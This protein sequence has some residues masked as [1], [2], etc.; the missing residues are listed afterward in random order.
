MIGALSFII[1]SLIFFTDSRGAFELLGDDL[2][3]LGI[4]GA[5]CAGSR[6]AGIIGRNPALLGYVSIPGLELFQRRLYNMKELRQSQVLLQGRILN[7]GFQ[8]GFHDFGNK[9]YRETAIA[10]SA[11]RIIAGKVSVGVRFTAFNL[12]IKDNGSSWAGGMRGGIVWRPLP[13]FALGLTGDNLNRPV[14]GACRERLPVRFQGGVS[15]FPGEWLS[16]YADIFKEERFP[17]EYRAGLEY[18][19]FKRLV[20]RGGLSDRPAR[21]SAGFDMSAGRFRL[22]YSFQTHHQLGVTHIYGVRFFLGKRAGG[23]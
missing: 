22:C 6:D 18:R 11:G 15:Y 19:G 13:E 2:G 12:Y 17:A 8:S 5:G 1:T 4:A 16:L 7:N 3:S 10:L 23:G 14:I 20:F 9:L 21:F